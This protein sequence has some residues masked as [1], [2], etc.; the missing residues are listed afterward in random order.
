MLSF[1]EVPNV[2]EG[3]AEEGWEE[4]QQN[5]KRQLHSRKLPDIMLA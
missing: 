2:G 1:V 3:R 5:R 4:K